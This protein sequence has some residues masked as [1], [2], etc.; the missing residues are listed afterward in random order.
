MDDLLDT[1]DLISGQNP[2]DIEGGK[3]V[4]DSYETIHKDIENASL[5]IV[6][7]TSA[8]AGVEIPVD[9]IIADIGTK[10]GWYLRE[11]KTV[12]HLRRVPGQQWDKLAEGKKQSPRLRE[13]IIILDTSHKRAN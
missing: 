3:E 5:W 9:L 4:T 10:V 12:R 8:Y 2:D 13:S 7:S 11:V 6:V 1:L